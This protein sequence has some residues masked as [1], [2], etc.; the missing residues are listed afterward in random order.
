MTSNNSWYRLSRT[1]YSIVSICSIITVTAC[2]HD[3]MKIEEVSQHDHNTIQESFGHHHHDHHRHLDETENAEIELCGV[4]VPTAAE[5]LVDQLNMLLWKFERAA[6]PDAA[7]I[8]YTIPTYFHI[9]QLNSSDPL[10]SDSNVNLYMNYLS[11]AFIAS[12]AP[13][14]FSLMDITRTVNATL[15]NNCS[16]LEGDYKPKL[17]RGGK[18][19]LNI[20]VCNMIPTGPNGGSITG[21][22]TL[23]SNKLGTNDGVTIVRTTPTDLNRPNTLV[24]EVVRR[25]IAN[26]GSCHC[27]ASMRSCSLT[28]LSPYSFYF[29]L[30]GHYLG[31]LHTFQD[32]CN[33]TRGGDRVDDTPYHISLAQQVNCRTPVSTWDTCPSLIG[34]DPV[35]NYMSKCALIERYKTLEKQN[36]LANTIYIILILSLFSIYG[37][38]SR[39]SHKVYARSGRTHDSTV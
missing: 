7:P 28:V 4:E 24:H 13:F 20:Y 17:K 27:K 33:T 36:S 31:L 3:R 23:P 39:V 34:L 29:P 10:V 35:D 38:E 26:F 30:Q 11:D 8:N 22:A 16:A 37:S 32:D 21:Y 2:D 9:L 25:N 1:L 14:R 6:D 5:R 19:T 15:S 12:N 18:E